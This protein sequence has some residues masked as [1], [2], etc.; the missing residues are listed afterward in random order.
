MKRALIVVFLG[1]GLLVS[2]GN[3]QSSE[4]EMPWFD[5]NYTQAVEQASESGVMLF[6]ETEW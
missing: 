3:D 1:I 6:F 2:C 4:T 5:G